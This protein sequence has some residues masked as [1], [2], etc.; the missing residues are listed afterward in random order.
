M[1]LWKLRAWSFAGWSPDGRAFAFVT[2]A[3]TAYIGSPATRRV[4]RLGRSSGRL[5]W[6]PDSTRLAWVTDRGTLKVTVRNG[7]SRTLPIGGYP[8]EWSPEGRRLLVFD[9]IRLTV[10]GVRD[11]QRHVVA[12]GPISVARWAGRR[13]IVYERNNPGCS[14]ELW[15]IQ[16][17]GTRLRRLTS[18]G[19]GKFDP[20]W[21]PDGSRIAFARTSARGECR[22]C[23]VE[24]YVV[25][26]DGS[27]P[28]RISG[29]R[30][31]P[32]PIASSPTW[33]ADGQWIAFSLTVS[34]PGGIFI[35]R[36]DGS[37]SVAQ[38]THFRSDDPSWSP[39]GTRIAFTSE[40]EGAGIYV[41]R[42]DGTDVRKVVSARQAAGLAWS[43][44]ASRIAYRTASAIAV[45]SL[46]DERSVELKRTDPRKCFPSGLA[47]SPDGEWIAY[48]DC[49][50]PPL[51]SDLFAVRV[52][53]SATRR[54]TRDRAPDF[55]ASW[56]AVASPDT[57]GSRSLPLSRTAERR[58]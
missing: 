6:S 53:G 5:S 32:D 45:V 57:F 48:E 1:R 19:F 47:W 40:R 52:D 36:A 51:T 43:P 9:G 56:H 3:G 39:D 13:T 25:A 21:S 49:A 27:N 15:T 41:M 23:N 50:G 17:D 30:H 33:S 20:A 28:R 14:S 37:G 46:L 38:V 42:P 34:D 8:L 7:K 11:T 12:S 44:D 2:E 4:K 16:P 55:G 54:L 58:Q 29:S 18:D 24:I 22:H 35:A 26:R 31:E 10:I